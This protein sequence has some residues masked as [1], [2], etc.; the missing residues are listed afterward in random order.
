MAAST[1]TAK[2]GALIA[3]TDLAKVYFATRGPVGIDNDWTEEVWT[4]KNSL[5][6]D[7]VQGTKTEINVDQTTTAIAVKYA[8]GT[9]TFSFRVP[10]MANAGVTTFYD[11]VVR[12]GA[13]GEI[14]S[15]V[16]GETLNDT[17]VGYGYSLALK[18]VADK[19][20][21]L[22][23]TNGW[24]IIFPHCEMVASLKKSGEDVWT[25][26]ITGTVL[27]GDGGG[28]ENA[29]VIFLEPGVPTP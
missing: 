25:M 8:A 17:F 11:T 21:M 7:Q 28:N 15:A 23:Y 24:G 19:M 4:L 18:T 3:Q 27:A 10:D 20:V 14:G 29:D 16:K 9:T 5:T 2:T 12:V 22:I 6:F 26:D 13:P 1:Y